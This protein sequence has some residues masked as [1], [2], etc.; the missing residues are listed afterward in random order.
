MATSS[1][2]ADQH[3]SQQRYIGSYAEFIKEREKV[4]KAAYLQ[5]RHN[6]IERAVQERKRDMESRTVT[7]RDGKRVGTTAA[8]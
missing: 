7:L 6:I 8:K 4:A 2:E 5:M 1:S 3:Q